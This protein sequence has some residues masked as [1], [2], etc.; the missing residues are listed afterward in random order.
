MTLLWFILIVPGLA[1]IYFMFIRRELEQLPPLRK[2]YAEADGFWAKAWA[3]CGKSLTIAWS[4]IVMSIGAVLQLL[5][6]IAA[7][8]GDPDFK[9]QIANLQLDPKIMGYIA[10]A[11]SLVTILSRIR[12]IGKAS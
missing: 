1:C 8:I 7:S 5:D 3:L 12:S 10:I 11:I 6:P 4:Y 9:N 2:F